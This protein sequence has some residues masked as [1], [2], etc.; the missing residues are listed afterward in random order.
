MQARVVHESNSITNPE[1]VIHSYKTTRNKYLVLSV[2]L[3]L[4]SQGPIFIMT[5]ISNVNR[6]M[7]ILK[8]EVF[9]PVS[10]IVIV[11]NEAIREANNSEF[12]LGA[13][14]WSCNFEKGLKLTQDI[15]K[16][17]SKLMKWQGLTPGC[18]LVE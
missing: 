13:S 15:K 12:G 2:I 4:H 3:K 16:E 18:R 6:E 7:S 5:V 17:L 10:P 9:G 14:I 8:E 11:E 1:K